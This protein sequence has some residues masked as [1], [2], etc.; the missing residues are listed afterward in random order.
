MCEDGKVYR[1]G[2]IRYTLPLAWLA[3]RWRR[4][5]DR[6]AAA[7]GRPHGRSASTNIASHGPQ[8]SALCL[9]STLSHPVSPACRLLTGFLLSSKPTAQNL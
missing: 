6:D 7:R 3:V 4:M 9:T 5:C 2:E 1:R 8:P